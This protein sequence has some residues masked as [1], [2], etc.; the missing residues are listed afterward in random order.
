[1]KQYHKYL[2]AVFTV[3]AILSG[4]AGGQSGKIEN[5]AI[6]NIQGKRCIFYDIV[7]SLPENGILILNFTSIKCK[8]C[9]K[10]IP[11]LVS[12]T[13]KS[14]NSAKIMF[15]YAENAAL[16]QPGAAELGITDRAYVDPFGN[17]QK[18]FGVKKIPA[19]II[20]SK[21]YIQLCRFDG[22]TRENI[23]GIEKVVNK[24]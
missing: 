23:R 6:Y 2:F 12:S 10:E 3:L 21:N 24:K 22:Y 20:I 1:M 8:P 9:R 15:I 18:I 5:F 4:E 19:T 14:G 17:I 16:A 11:E 13:S 7:N